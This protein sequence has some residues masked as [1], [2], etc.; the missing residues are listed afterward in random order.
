MVKLSA[1]KLPALAAALLAPALVGCAQPQPQTPLA[2][3]A[4]SYGTPSLEIVAN[5]QL[6]V[7]VDVPTT[8]DCPLLS[9]KLTATYDGAPMKVSR[10]GYD[11]TSDSCYPI[12]FWFDAPPMAAIDGFEKS[13]NSTEL[14]LADESATWRVQTSKLF[15]NDFVDDAANHRVLWTDVATITSAQILPAQSYT[16]EGNAVVYPAGGHVDWIAALSHPVATTC[17]GPA[18]CLVNVQGSRTLHP[19]AP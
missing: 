5:G 17:D 14:Q 4:T 11:T 3:L 10:G 6:N 13:T 8:G 2:Q 16:I 7:L 18:H 15:A 19:T 12:A 1:A 9:D